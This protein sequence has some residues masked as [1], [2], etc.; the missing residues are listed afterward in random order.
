M[1]LTS[2]TKDYT[3]TRSHEIPMF[4]GISYIPRDIP[5]SVLMA[6]ND[7]GEHMEECT[8]SNTAR[9]YAPLKKFT[10]F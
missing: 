2:C 9:Q 6:C 3:I 5:T 4:T 10:L 1:K 8:R 7:D